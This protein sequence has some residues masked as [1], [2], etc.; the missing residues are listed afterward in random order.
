[1]GVGAFDGAKEI[2]ACSINGSS[3]LLFPLFPASMVPASIARATTST[4]TRYV[5]GFLLVVTCV[6]VAVY[7]QEFQRPVPCSFVRC[8]E[9]DSGYDFV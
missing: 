7:A 5:M 2:V 6:N 8:T 1:M 9:A 4:A 3:Y